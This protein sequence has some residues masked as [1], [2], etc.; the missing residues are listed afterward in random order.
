MERPV[1]RPADVKKRALV[2]HALRNKLTA[3]KL[4]EQTNVTVSLCTVQRVLFEE[5]K[6]IFSPLENSPKLEKNVMK[7]VVSNGTKK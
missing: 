6:L 3:R 7:G 5:S 2:R 4:Q 1:V